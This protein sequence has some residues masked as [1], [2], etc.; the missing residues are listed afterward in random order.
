MADQFVVSVVWAP[1]AGREEA[2]RLKVAPGTTIAQAVAASGLAAFQPAHGA[3]GTKYGVW[4]KRAAPE[5]PVADGDR[6]EIY[7]PLQVDPK[8]ARARRARK[9]Q[10]PN[11][12]NAAG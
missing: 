3:E 12:K 9:H 5:S 10:F 11:Q 6:I 2:A 1:Q 8:L 4:G 7:R